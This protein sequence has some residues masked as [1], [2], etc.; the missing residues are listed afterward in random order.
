MQLIVIKFYSF[1]NG[2]ELFL[3]KIYVMGAC[4]LPK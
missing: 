3:H 4:I 1:Y 2:F